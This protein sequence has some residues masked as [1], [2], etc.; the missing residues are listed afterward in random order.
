MKMTTQE[1]VNRLL[2][3]EWKVGEIRQINDEWCQCVAATCGCDG[4]YLQSNKQCRYYFQCTSTMREDNKSVI[5]KKLEKIGNPYIYNTNGDKGLVRMQ[6]YKLYDVNF[7]KECDSL[8]LVSSH[9]PK[10][11]S[12]EIKQPK[13]GAQKEKSITTKFKEYITQV[14]KEQ[15]E[16]DLD[17]LKKFNE[18]GISIDEFIKSQE[19]AQMRPFSLEAAKQGKPVCTR[20]GRKARII[21]FDRKFYNNGCNYPIVAA[22]NEDDDN[23]NEFI[24]TYT[25]DGL[26]AENE[27]NELDLIML[28]EKK[29]GWINVYRDCDGM[30]ITKDDN[31]YSLKDAAI[32]SAQMID[33]DN[34]VTTIKIQWEE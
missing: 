34:Y 18:S 27:V 20:N 8:M 11:I 19:A 3:T 21:C 33:R 29:E 5:F 31:I 1:L 32:A 28:P 14:S 25:Q 10:R 2:E 13:E 24:Y 26:F 22:I 6:E 17:L 16:K 7:C 4:C 23:N 9:N 12:I 30:N 15:L